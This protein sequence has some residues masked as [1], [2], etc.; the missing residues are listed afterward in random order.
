MNPLSQQFKEIYQQFHLAL[1][2]GD[3]RTARRLAEYAVALDK[4]RVEAWLLLAAVASPQASLFYLNH[5]LQIDPQNRRIRQG[6]HWAVN[7][8]RKAQPAPLLVG[9][10]IPHSIPTKNFVHARK[11]F[12]WP[13]ILLMVLFITTMLA[14]G[15]WFISSS[16]A[17]EDNRTIQEINYLL[18]ISLEKATRTPTY[19]PTLTPT[20]TLTLTLTPTPT[21]TPTVTLTPTDTST[22]Q[23]THTSEPPPVQANIPGLPPGVGLTDRWIDIDLSEQRTYAYQGNELVNSFLVSTGTWEHPTVTGT[24]NIYVKYTFADMSGPGYYL[25][26]VPYVMYFYKGYGLHGTYWHNKFGTPM[27]HGCVNLRTEDAGWL[28]DWASVGTTVHVHE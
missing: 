21:L 24:Y 18:E 12:P 5:A 27:S 17:K 22:P 26:S 14:S 10:I 8:L 20:M 19:T 15:G 25:S 11:G 3:T 6:I 7:R 16:F 9:N 1:K 13:A 2:N 23:P 28:F 4:D